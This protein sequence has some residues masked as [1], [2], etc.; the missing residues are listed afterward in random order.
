MD[1]VIREGHHKFMRHPHRPLVHARVPTPVMH[2]IKRCQNGSKSWQSSTSW[3]GFTANSHRR[4]RLRPAK[5]KWRRW[6]VRAPYFLPNSS[7]IDPYLAAYNSPEHPKELDEK[8]RT[9]IYMMIVSLPNKSNSSHPNHKTSS[10][11]PQQN[12]FLWIHPKFQN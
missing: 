3:H 9:Y 11:V 1:N 6:I 10:I 2:L 4:V 12:Q 7:E 8:D 5:G